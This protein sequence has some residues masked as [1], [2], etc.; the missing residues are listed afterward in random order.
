MQQLTTITGFCVQDFIEDM[1]SV[2]SVFRK[3]VLVMAI[4]SY[5]DNDEWMDQL[6]QREPSFPV[7]CD[8]R[9]EGSTIV[10]ETELTKIVLYDENRFNLKP[11]G[12]LYGFPECCIQWWEQ[13]TI[14]DEVSH[15]PTLF[16]GTGYIPCPECR[17]KSE[18]ELEATINKRRIAPLS[19]PHD[20][21]L[22][23]LILIAF[24]RKHGL[25]LG[26][27]LKGYEEQFDGFDYSAVF[28][29]KLK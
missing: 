26:D 16:D 23:E 18:E 20:E 8:L 5:T 6:I 21:S 17:Q 1:E 9:A 10:M 13:R 2:N 12:V 22:H 3:M 27:N 4:M 14:E 29:N 25:P 7:L 24:L 15:V 28:A 19:F 11:M